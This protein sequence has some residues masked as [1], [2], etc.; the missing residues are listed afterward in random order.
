MQTHQVLH[1]SGSIPS[2]LRK[3]HTSRLTSWCRFEAAALVAVHGLAQPAAHAATSTKQNNS[4]ALNLAESWD[5]LP[6]TADVAQWT[7]M[8]TTANSPILGTDLSW[9]GVKIVSPGGLVTLAAGNTTAIKLGRA[10]KIV[11]KP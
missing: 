8:V 2:V 4:T 10:A 9:L 7:S 5:T 6:G 11:C 3:S 1:S